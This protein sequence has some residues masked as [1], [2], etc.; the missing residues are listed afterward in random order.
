MLA[1]ISLFA[2]LLAVS[3]Q[4]VPQPASDAP[5][6]VPTAR[7]VP[8]EPLPVAPEPRPVRTAEERDTRLYGPTVTIAGVTARTT[9]LES[10]ALAFYQ[11]GQYENALEAYTRW[12]PKS[13]CAN[14]SF[15]MHDTRS[16]RIA[17][18]H[19]H[20]RDHTAAA[21][22]CLEAAG[23]QTMGDSGVAA[24]TI[25]LYR[26]AG[27]LDDVGPLLDAIEKDMLDKQHANARLLTPAERFNLLGPRGTLVV[28]NQLKV[29]RLDELKPWP[30]GVPKPPKGSLP[31]ALPR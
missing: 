17:L 26:E 15:S 16:R 4:S 6:M 5:D 7:P 10:V 2:T 11:Q 24:F 13:F 19:S 21:R 31:K 8:A 14:C 29:A 18:C 1:R 3:C 9:Q 22:A 20:L 25:Q 27:Q 28:R 23:K 12:T 30:E